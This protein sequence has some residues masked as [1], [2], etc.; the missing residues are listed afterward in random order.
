MGYQFWLKYC[1]FIYFFYC[2]WG[3]TSIFKYLLHECISWVIANSSLLLVNCPLCS[4]PFL[5][6]YFLASVDRCMGPQYL[7]LVI[8]HS[9]LIRLWIHSF[10]ALYIFSCYFSYTES[11]CLTLTTQCLFILK[12][13]LMFLLNHPPSL[14]ITDSSIPVFLYRLT[15][16]NYSTLNNFSLSCFLVVNMW[17]SYPVH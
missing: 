17:N 9:V 15:A 7:F 10:H 5:S 16:P 14:L 12:A 3:W 13:H 11:P 4:F 2:K 8:T 6:L 1:H